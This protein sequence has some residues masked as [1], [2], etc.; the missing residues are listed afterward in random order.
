MLG[1]RTIFEVG[2]VGMGG[3]EVDC[4]PADMVASGVLEA[5]TVGLCA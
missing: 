3:I 5:T 4:E 1:L 2:A